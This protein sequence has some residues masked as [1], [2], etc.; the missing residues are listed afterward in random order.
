MPFLMASIKLVSS[1]QDNLY[2]LTFYKK[3]PP[4]KTD[5]TIYIIACLDFIRSAF[6]ASDLQLEAVLKHHPVIARRLKNE[7]LPFEKIYFF[8]LPIWKRY[9]K[10]KDISWK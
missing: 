8:N 1:K 10:A 5:A 3:Q 2:I 7:R 6:I 9:K 4:N